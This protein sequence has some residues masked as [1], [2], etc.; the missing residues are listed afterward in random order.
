M[1][2]NHLESVPSKITKLKQISPILSVAR[3]LMSLHVA[4]VMGNIDSIVKLGRMHLICLMG[5]SI[6]LFIWK[7]PKIQNYC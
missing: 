2:E 4:Q 7:H 5:P 1:L 3:I 6:A